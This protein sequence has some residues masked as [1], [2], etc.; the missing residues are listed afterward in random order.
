MSGPSAKSAE[1]AALGEAKRDFVRGVLIAGALS[2]FCNIFALSAPLF[3]QEVFQRVLNTRNIGTLGMLAIAC[4][5]GTVVF[6]GLEYLRSCIAILL[7]DR[8]ARD[9]TVPVLQ[10]ATAEVPGRSNEATQAV[11][12]LNDLRLFLGGNA[13]GIALDLAWTPLLVV[14]LF[15]LH[16]A[17]GI[18]AVVCA[19]IL[20]ALNLAA[21]LLT[22]KPIAEANANAAASLNE[23]A[24]SIRNAE[25]VDGLGML[26]AI[27]VR[28]ERT[29]YQTLRK[30]DQAGRSSKA[31]AAAVKACRLSMTGGMI[32]VGVLLV[33]D[34]AVAAG[35]MLA[36]NMIV[37]KLLQPFE[38]V[39][40][41]RREWVFALAAYN[42]VKALLGA[43]G[44]RRGTMVLPRPEGRLV[45]ERLLYIPPG[46]DRPALRNISFEIVPGEALGIVGSSASGKSTLARL[47]VGIAEP[48]AGGIY[49]D[50][51]STYHWSRA[52]F[53]RYVG[54]LPQSVSLLDGTIFE[55][56]ARM[57]TDADPRKVIDA[58]KR[59]GVHQT[60]MALPFGYSTAVGETMHSLSGG[61]RQRVALARALFGRP[62]LVVLDEPNSALDTAGE[63]SLL[64]AIGAAKADGAAVIVIAHRPSVLTGVDKLLILKDG[65]VE[66]Y[67][68]REA[69]T[70]ALETP[71]LHVVKQ[72]PAE[73]EM[74][75]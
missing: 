28:W 58:A 36:A 74:I 30:L 70:A 63:A 40:A 7:A 75:A 66:R 1:H 17:Y 27:A 56:I 55:N 5:I 61:Q 65:A 59:A 22:K 14:V 19:A 34:N 41:G 20:V 24:V 54:Y 73:R 11:R 42:R 16:P 38:Q 8:M 25:A 53:G 68:A 60:I 71:S 72:I 37:A 46:T 32:L 18:F 52:D 9:L 50:G 4:V 67:G 26:P 2:A 39:V 62:R 3:N 31:F 13:V 64:Q 57:Q 44:S 10:A 33:L 48:T 15:L 51:H 43:S 49:L 69:I 23:M 47:I 45:V 35:S 29:Q 12:D 6:A 21:E